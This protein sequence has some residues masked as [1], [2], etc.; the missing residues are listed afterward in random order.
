MRDSQTQNAE[1]NDFEVSEFDEGSSVG[2][3]Q[4]R[5]GRFAK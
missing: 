3:I 1:P 2:R 4:S 5:S